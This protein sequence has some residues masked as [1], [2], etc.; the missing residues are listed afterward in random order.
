MSAEVHVVGAGLAG[1][2]AA[3]ALMQ[4]G[5]SVALYEAG[6][7]AGGRCRSYFD[8]ALAARIDNGN[9]L[10]LS[11]NRSAHRYLQRLGTRHTLTGPGRPLFPFLDLTSG[12]HWMLRL[13]SG[14]LPWWIGFRQRRIPGTRMADYLGLWRL[15]RPT[16]GTTVTALMGKSRLWRRLLEP[17]AVAAL[18]TLPE[19]AS[20]TL[21]AAVVRE[22]LLAGGAACIPA[23][24]GQGLSESLIDPAVELL[25]VGGV[26]VAFGRRIAALEVEGGRVTALYTPDGPIVIAP[27]SWVVLAV[28]PWVAAD[29][30]PDLVAPDQFEAILN[31]HF[32]LPRSP[33]VPWSEAGFI[34]LIGG[35]AQWVFVKSDIVS[36]TISAANSMVDRAAEDIAAAV[37]P[38]VRSACGLSG[39]IP[40]WRVVKERRAT[41]AATEAQDRRRP[42]QR[43]IFTNLVLAGDWVATG[44]PATIEGA[45][46]SGDTAAAIVLSGS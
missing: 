24:P 38:D 5:R 35:V 46:R 12:E 9:H 31:I 7:V 14:R 3:L 32:R 45:I 10:L 26:A 19:Q 37:W 29:L 36:V 8:R 28:P 1:L 39:E 13:S 42:G 30:V 21:F 43:T 6:P 16:A 11:G 33:C 22:T 20:A 41:F 2:T 40:R 15:L 25:R 18:N 44:L 34:G 4:A 27:G 17:L 23:F